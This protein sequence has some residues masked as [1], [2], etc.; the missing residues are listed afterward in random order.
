MSKLLGSS[1]LAQSAERCDLSPAGEK[2]GAPAAPPR[3]ARGTRSE[4]GS[5]HDLARP[6]DASTD[7][8]PQRPSL[9]VK[10]HRRGGAAGAAAC[11]RETWLSEVE[12]EVARLKDA[13]AA[14]KMLG[15]LWAS[16]TNRAEEEN[17]RVDLLLCQIAAFSSEAWV[18]PAAAEG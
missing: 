17:R 3:A 6:Q 4:V 16:V 15:R 11:A 9:A 12:E 13:Q 1:V 5:A 8:T 14:R 2:D 7:T 18:P 10:R